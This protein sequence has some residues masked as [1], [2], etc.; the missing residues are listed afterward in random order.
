MIRCIIS[1]FS[2]DHPGR[3]EKSIL[4]KGKSGYA[5]ISWEAMLV[6]QRKNDGSS[7]YSVGNKDRSRGSP[8]IFCRQDINLEMRRG[9]NWVDGGAM[10]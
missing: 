10:E 3:G 2:K 7:D 4:N 1:K 6:I 5:A 9:K 8:N